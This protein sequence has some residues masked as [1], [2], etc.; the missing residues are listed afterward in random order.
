M[1]FSSQSP[2]GFVFQQV[3]RG[4]FTETCPGHRLTGSQKMPFTWTH[5]APSV[6]ALSCSCSWDAFLKS[7]SRKQVQ[8]AAPR[9]IWFNRGDLGAVNGY[10]PGPLVVADSILNA[11]SGLAGCTRMLTTWSLNRAQDYHQSNS[12]IILI[13]NKCSHPPISKSGPARV[14]RD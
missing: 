7:P 13:G 10:F 2:L 14:D 12:S 3:H 8:S 9:L 6:T 1:I 4:G 11:V 5:H